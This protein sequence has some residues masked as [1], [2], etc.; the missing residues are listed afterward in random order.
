MPELPEVETVRRGLAPAMEGAVIERLELRRG[1]LR[2]PF[3]L[4][5]AASVACQRI[6]SLSRRAKYLLIDLDNGMTVVAHLGMSGSFRIEAGEAAVTPGE[7]HHPRS[8][9]E[10]HD[11]VIFHLVRDGEVMR[12]VY[13]DPRRFGFMDIVARAEMAAHPFFRD[14]GPEP[15][16]NALSPEGLAKRFSGKAQPLKSTLLDQK[17]IAG[18]GNIY[19]C[20][21]LW[22]A[23]LSP[24][25]ASGTLS[26]KTGKPRETLVRL[27]ACIRD[28]IADAIA[29]GG[30]SLRDHI[31]TDGSLGY[32]Q[33]SFSVYDREGEACRTEGCGGTVGRIVQAGRSTFYCATC[34]K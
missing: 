21:A 18:L 14:L 17:T 4:E 28:V 8:K 15:T 16:G 26:T 13:N 3:P 25:R 12:V 19:V 11:H 31:Q 7:F 24:L 1:D 30:S 5:F 23:H 29:A 32:F 2:F 22:R 34:Q 27:V 33:H 6:A 20:E 10:V 9:N